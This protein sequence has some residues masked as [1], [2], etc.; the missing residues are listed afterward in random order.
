M[1]D[2]ILELKQLLG[3]QTVF[4]GW[5]RGV[6]GGNLR[7]KHLRIDNM[8][9][10]YLANLK[11]GNIGVALGEV[12]DG[13]CV[14]DCDSDELADSFASANPKLVTLQTR[15]SRGRSFWFRFISD[16]PRKSSK[17]KIGKTEV[18][19]FRCNG[20]QSIVWGTH[21]DTNRPYEFVERKPAAVIEFTDIIWP[22]E[23]LNPPTLQSNR[24]TDVISV[25]QSLRLSVTPSLCLS[26]NSIDCAVELSLPKRKHQNNNALFI[27]ARALRNFAETNGPLT[28]EIKMQAFS[29]WYDQALARGLLREDQ[30]R[31]EYMGEFFTAFRKVKLPLG[32]SPAEQA[33]LLAKTEPLPAEAAKFT[34]EHGKLLVA[35]C[36]QLEKAA[37]DGLWHLSYHTAAKLLG[38]SHVQ[39]GYLLT[40]MVEFGILR[41]VKQPTAMKATRYR[42]IKGA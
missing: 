3:N 1:T 35:I 39:T 18:G 5:Q 9:P 14:V 20:N 34:S 12:S 17:L 16:Y 6:K 8:T 15:G 42:Y 40:V 24:D 28:I 32:Q 22:A 31:E 36:Y 7:W 19:E 11:H 27:L 21:P 33:F 25:T 26:V 38:I 41:V 37:R 10:G 30:T 13:L 2:P 23:V 4:I 29:R